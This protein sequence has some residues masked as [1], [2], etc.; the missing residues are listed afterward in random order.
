[1]LK[2]FKGGQFKEDT[3]LLSILFVLYLEEHLLVKENV[4]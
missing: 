3:F 4:C 1:M 2:F